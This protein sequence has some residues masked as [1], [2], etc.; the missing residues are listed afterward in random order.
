MCL[1]IWPAP[2]PQPSWFLFALLPSWILCPVFVFPDQSSAAFFRYRI[3]VIK[4]EINGGSDNSAAGR[5]AGTRCFA[6]HQKPFAVAVFFLIC[7]DTTCGGASSAAPSLLRA[8][9]RRKPVCQQPTAF[10]SCRI[11]CSPSGDK[12][13]QCK[14]W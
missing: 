13:W 4:A 2:P 11:F 7:M 12:L 8:C 14:M 5:A 10:F 9:N 3:A 6:I 1:Q